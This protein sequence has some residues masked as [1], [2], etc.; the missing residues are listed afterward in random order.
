M[1]DKRPDSKSPLADDMNS[2]I[3]SQLPSLVHTIESNMGPVLRTGPSGIEN[4]SAW[5][6]S[7]GPEKGSAASHFL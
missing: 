2:V 7:Q 5:G 3:S 1:Q 6:H 4:E